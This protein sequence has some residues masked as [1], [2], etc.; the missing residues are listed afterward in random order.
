[1]K[2]ITFTLTKSGKMRYETHVLNHIKNE[3]EAM[4]WGIRNICDDGWYI[5]NI[6]I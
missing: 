2:S 5:I 1:M 4:S 6:K 3:T